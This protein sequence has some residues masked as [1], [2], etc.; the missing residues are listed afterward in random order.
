MRKSG[1]NHGRLGGNLRSAHATFGRLFRDAFERGCLRMIIAW[2]GERAIAG[3][4]S[5]V[6]DV[7]KTYNLYQL[8]YDREYGRFS[9]GKVVA[10]LAIRDAIEREYAV[11]DFLRGDEQYKR[12]YAQD[13]VTTSHYRMMRRT[14]R[15]VAYDG[16][17]PV[18]R[19]LKAAAVRVV[20][21]PGRTV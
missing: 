16:V 18:Y 5:F 2:D 9:P 12:W 1:P 6:E 8:A 10:S 4:A 14:I 3:A 21:G 7:H 13:V 17:Y 20:Y 11:F 15:S 19:A